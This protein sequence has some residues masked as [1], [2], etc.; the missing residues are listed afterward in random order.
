MMQDVHFPNAT[1]RSRQRP[2]EDLHGPE[3]RL[4]YQDGHEVG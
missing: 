2:D 4:H 3:R 1:V